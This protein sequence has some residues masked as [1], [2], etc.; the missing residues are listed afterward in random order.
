MIT[1]DA[2]GPRPLVHPSAETTYRRARSKA[3][4]A[5]CK[6]GECERKV[7]Q[8]AKADKKQSCPGDTDSCTDPLHVWIIRASAFLM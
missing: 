2:T 6:I 1:A 4:A 5:P 3:K 7:S 8:P